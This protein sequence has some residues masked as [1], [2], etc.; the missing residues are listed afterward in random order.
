M[1]YCQPFSSPEIS[2]TAQK[3][4]QRTKDKNFF[5]ECASGFYLSNRAGACLQHAMAAASIATR[6]RY[7]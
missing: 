6:N 4:K 5:I 3:L 7:D 1:N 2:S